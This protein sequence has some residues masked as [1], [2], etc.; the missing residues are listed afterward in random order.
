MNLN[1]IHEKL[2]SYKEARGVWVKTV[3]S[4]YK[5]L[6][7]VLDH[8]LVLPYVELTSEGDIEYSWNEETITLQI[9]ISGSKYD[10]YVYFRQSRVGDLGE[11]K[12]EN[13]E[14]PLIV[15]HE[16]QL[17]YLVKVEAGDQVGFIKRYYITE[18]S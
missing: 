18:G 9:T 7:Y 13:F 16:L 14:L 4:A 1:E 6:S 17:E 5:V 11:G 12:V 15:L 10:Y 2:K 3:Q 8:R